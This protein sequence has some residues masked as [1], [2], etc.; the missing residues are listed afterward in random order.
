MKTMP[1]VMANVW[2]RIG[3][4]DGCNNQK[5]KDRKTHQRQS[6]MPAHT[7]PRNAHPTWIQLLETLK[8]RLRQFLRDVAVHLIPLPPRVLRRVDV[9]PR[10]AAE[11]V[12]VV[13]ALDVQ[14]P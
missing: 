1:Q 4:S 9:E 8:Q 2:M 11:I 12:L 5:E 3:R 13:F 7:M 10:P 14:A 6:P